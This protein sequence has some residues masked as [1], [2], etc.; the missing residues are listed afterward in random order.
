LSKQRQEHVRRTAV[1]FDHLSEHYD[2]YAQ[3]RRDYLEQIDRAMMRV[4][5]RHEPCS[6]LDIGCGTGR[7]LG[8]LTNAFPASNGLGVDV[9]SQM[10]DTC[11]AKGLPAVQADFIEY[12]PARRVDV[13]LFEFNV[14]GYLIV[15]NGLQATLEH[16][17]R[18]VNER[19]SIVFD[20]LNP[21]CVTYARLR[22]T[23]PD[24]LRRYKRLRTNGE[25]VEF[26]YSVEDNPIT[27]GITRAQRIAKYYQ[28]AGYKV[29]RRLVKYADHRWLKPLPPVLTSH[30]LLSVT[31]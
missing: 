22:D 5:G 31:R 2:R 9:S 26:Q 4:V 10:V 23:V 27:M 29:Q 13:L 25:V 30:Y 20:I 21:L 15:Q 3:K 28:D 11:L 16:T 12:R 24:A 17:R 6:F 7:L 19:G 1:H 14:F 8:K 18:L